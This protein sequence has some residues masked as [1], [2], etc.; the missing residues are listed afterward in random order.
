MA[1]LSLFLLG[2]TRIMMAEEVVIVKPR[3]ALALLIYLAV[4]GERHARDSLATLLWPDSDQRQARHSLRS[5]L[6]ELKQTLGTEWLEADRESVGLRAG[7]WLDVAQFQQHLA[8][9]S[10]DAQTLIEAST[11]YR[12][13]FLSGFTLPD[14]PEFDERQF[15]QTESL[16]QTL[17]SSLEQLVSLLSNR[18][19][20]ETAVSYARRWL[21]LDLLHEPAHRQLMQLYAQTGQQASALKQYEQCRQI[22]GNELGILPSLQTTTLYDNIRA[23]QLKTDSFIFPAQRLPRHNLPTQ[24][25]FFI[26]REAEL[27][28]LEQWLLT[29]HCRVVTI[30][31]IGGIG[32]T[33]LAAKLAH[34]LKEQGDKDLFEH[35]IWRSLLNAP[36]LA[37]LLSDLL[38]SLHVQQPV[39]LSLDLDRQL[40]LLLGYLRHTRCLLILDNVESI[41]QE[42]GR[43]GAYRPGYE[44]YGQLVSQLGKVEHQSCL[45]LTSRERP[46]GLKRLERNSPKVRSLLLSGLPAEAGQKILQRH[47]L[48]IPK[49][50]TSTLVDGYSGNPLALNLV[51]ETIQELFKG[52]ITTFLAAE[53]PIFDDI[54]D[55]L[56][57]HFARL[58]RLEQEI[59]TWLAL[60]REAVSA[61][62]LWDNLLQ[63]P[64][65]RV[66]LEAMRALQRRS[67]LER[68][69]DG[70]I[71]QNVVT[72]YTTDKFIGQVCQ[73]IEHL[74]SAPGSVNLDDEIQY[75]NHHAFLKAQ[76]KDYVRQSQNRL[77]LRP[78]AEQLLSR[79]GQVG[80]EEALQQLLVALPKKSPPVPGYAG[81]NILNLLLYLK[82]DLSRYDFSRITVWQAYLQGMNLQ[83][84]NFSSADLSQVAFT[85]TFGAIEIV[86][87]SPDG[88]LIAAGMADGQVRVWQAA[89]GRPLWVWQAHIGNTISICFSPDGHTLASGGMDQSVRLWDVTSGQ[90]LQIFKGHTGSW[91]NSVCFSPDGQILASG[92]DDQ[93]VRLWDVTSGLALQIFQGHTDWVNSVCFSPNSYLLASGS[94]DHTIRLWDVTTGQPLQTWQGHTGQ[95]RSVCFSP[96]GQILA[97]G[98]AD[99]TVRLWEVSSG[100]ELQAFH[101]HTN[102]V[103]SVCF[104]PNGQ[105][106]A[107]GS[108]DQT[109]RLWDVAS[110]QVLQAF[111]VHK[112]RFSSICFSPDGHILASGGG[113]QSVRFWEVTSGQVLRAYQGYINW[114]ESV[115]FSPDGQFLASG[116]A[117]Q[118]VRLWEVASGQVLQTFQAHLGGVNSVCFSPNGQI[119]ASGGGDQTVR[120]W[121]LTS[122]KVLQ[123]FQGHRD[124]VRVVCFSPDGQSLASGGGDQ[125]I[126]LW[127]VASGQ[128]LYT[129]QDQTSRVSSLCFSPDGH[130]LAGGG[131]E[132]LVCLWDIA[133]GQTR[134]TF[135]GH[136]G[137]V[138]SVC[139]SPDGQTLASGGAD[140]SVR[141]WDL[142]NGKVIQ[143][144]Q[145]HTGWVRSICFSPDGQ[146]LASGAADQTVHLWDIASGQVLQILQG[147]TDWVRSICF[148]PDGQTLASGSTDGTIK[149]WDLQTGKCLKTFRADRPYERMNIAGVIGLTTAQKATLKALGA[150]ENSEQETDIASE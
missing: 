73:E 90:A 29:D 27:A 107:S 111:Q 49:E 9:K 135:Q 35:I 139:F 22:L 110:G 46:R 150:V 2:P 99:Q 71:L 65:R 102:W 76:V 92:G 125:T 72:E 140:Q 88:Q 51:S 1:N 57:Q 36:P 115:C 15:F 89:D 95:L 54:R 86:V 148:S 31:G 39:G 47:G 63:P 58:S 14:C 146:S 48:S 82:S 147:H 100:R 32:K 149:L 7:Y 64:S 37:D 119:L 50:M 85:D 10:A 124:W 141:L 43:A 87:F 138:S 68:G 103:N 84:V 120:L 4:T 26:G 113:D 137:W 79:L 96:D 116:S 136:T 44:A 24:T 28:Q 17:A 11:L 13:D 127:D 42:K 117:D 121:D 94:A 142:T 19:D 129:F 16:R 69:E 23:R 131:L 134:Q 66:F 106:L 67:L 18:G 56:D 77:I 128:P 132:Q 114:V 59:V 133:S 123:T 101:V 38:Q 34:A 112:G 30:L 41:L 122:C 33:A 118:S 144:Y 40:N 53:T 105:I 61:Q 83:D 143:T 21:A 108:D 55:V 81:G 62:T 145:G 60:E 80:F 3:K 5:R 104:S 74:A 52:D 126:R 20:F 91:V 6:S 97:S 45:L 25:I 12:D 93:T 78:I 130:T 70:L 8:S 75:L 98:S 109:I